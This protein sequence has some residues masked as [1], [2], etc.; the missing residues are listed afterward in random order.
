V[1]CLRE[2]LKCENDDNPTDNEITCEEEK[3]K[4]VISLKRS[5]EA[6]HKKIVTDLKE[7]THLGR[8]D[9]P[10]TVFLKHI[11]TMDHQ[12][13]LVEIKKDLLLLR[14]EIKLNVLQ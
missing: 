1:F 12:G 8:D 10:S 11:R 4:S 2:L 7:G 3:F 13:A 14:L 6:R 5:D 9:H